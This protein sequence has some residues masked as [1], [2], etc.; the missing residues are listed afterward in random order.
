VEQPLQQAAQRAQA[1]DVEADHRAEEVRYH[2][3]KALI[4]FVFYEKICNIHSTLASRAR[5]PDPL[6]SVIIF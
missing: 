1:G 5:D 6:G 4:Y 2:S 3:K